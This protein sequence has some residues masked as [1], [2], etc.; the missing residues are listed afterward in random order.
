MDA[1]D[2]DFESAIAAERGTP[3]GGSIK[4]GVGWLVWADGRQHPAV[5][6]QVNDEAAAIVTQFALRMESFAV[7]LET[8]MDVFH[9]ASEMMP[10][11]DVQP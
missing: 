9:R 10:A 7:L 8:M 2:A 1:R 4:F 5:A 6:V 11:Q 3:S